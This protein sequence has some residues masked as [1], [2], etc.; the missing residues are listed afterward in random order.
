MKRIWIFALALVLLAPLAALCSPGV[1]V[2]EQAKA[3]IGKLRALQLPG[4]ELTSLA[5]EAD[6]VRVEGRTHNGANIAKLMK[7]IE[8]DIG[9]PKPLEISAVIN[10]DHAPV[11]FKILVTPYAGDAPS[12][13]AAGAAAGR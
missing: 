12:P 10:D 5:V 11:G 2:D 7:L 9:S 6:K 4:V 13:T 8:Q 1:E 3:A